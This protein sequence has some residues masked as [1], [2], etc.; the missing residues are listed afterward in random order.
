MPILHWV[1][2]GNNPGRTAAYFKTAT[3]FMV[4]HN[5][6][7]ALVTSGDFRRDLQDG[8]RNALIALLSDPQRFEEPFASPGAMVFKLKAGTHLG[9]QA[10]GSWWAGVRDSIPTVQ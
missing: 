4:E 8:G 1:T 3:D 9:M 5:L 6:E 7:Y 2:Y 10:A